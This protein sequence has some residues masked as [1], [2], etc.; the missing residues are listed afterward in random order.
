MAKIYPVIMCGG[1]GARLWPLSRK[2][3]PKQYLSLVDNQ[4][5][6]EATVARMSHAPE[7]VEVAPVTL[8]CG[9]GQETIAADQ[10]RAAG[11]EPLAVIVEP[12]GRNTAAVAAT[13]ALHIQ[14]LDPEAAVLLLP[15][16]HYISQ[17]EGFWAGVAKG[18]PALET[19]KLVTLGIEPTGPET[20]YGYIQ[21]G[22]QIGEDLHQVESFREKPDRVTAEAYLK[23]GDYHWNAGIFLFSAM[24]MIDEFQ[25]LGPDI[26]QNSKAA[27]DKA[28]R[29]GVEVHLDAEAFGAC[30]S[31]PVDIEIMERTERAAV[32]APVRAGWDDI[33][34]WSALSE[35]KAVLEDR[36]G[37]PQTGDVIAID[38][39]GGLV[40]SDGPLVAAIGLRDVV[41]VA[42]GEAVLVV[43]KEQ[44]QRVKEIVS[45]LKNDGRMEHL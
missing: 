14:A 11:V 2:A 33:G 43:A 31:E 41:V 16:D 38:C 37:S 32:V 36:G 29:S 13:A 45:R 22:Q 12:F 8:I 9:E 7:G 3:S 30:R 17:P 34:S 40:R 6:L 24:A 10:A 44:A 4:T 15:A 28:R 5:L 25:A 20:G 39:E 35:L 26:L 23:T 21:S 1:A 42:T 27:L 19:G 18:M